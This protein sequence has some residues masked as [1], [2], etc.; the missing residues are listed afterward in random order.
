M[1]LL[2]FGKMENQARAQRIAREIVKPLAV[3]DLECIIGNSMG[4]S[5]GKHDRLFAAVDPDY[6][7]LEKGLAEI[8]QQL[9]SLPK[10]VQS[11]FSEYSDLMIQEDAIRQLAWFHLGF[12]A[13]L[14]LLGA[15]PDMH[16]VNGGAQAKLKGG[17]AL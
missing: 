6:P 12:Q 7:A 3:S 1:S 10:E 14:R 11:L 15:P 16:V 17:C 8:D 2:Y 4:V 13:A 5:S 9:K